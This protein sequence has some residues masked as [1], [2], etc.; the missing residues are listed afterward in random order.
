[1]PQSVFKGLT[2]IQYL[3]SENAA[4][5]LEAPGI[6]AAVNQYILCE[7]QNSQICI[8]RE[9]RTFLTMTC[10]HVVYLRNR[11]SIVNHYFHMF[12]T[13]EGVKTLDGKIGCKQLRGTDMMLPLS[14]EPS[15]TCSHIIH[16]STPPLKGCIR[17]HSDIYWRTANSIKTTV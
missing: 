14:G 2:S 10:N 9:L 6:W 17:I 12:P 13:E 8:T 7:T 1:M 3:G 15:P 4:T 5:T 11:R 16:H